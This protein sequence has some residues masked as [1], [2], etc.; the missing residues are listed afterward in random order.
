MNIYPLIWRLPVPILGHIEIT[1]YG[2]MMM[3]GFLMG[4]WLI[5]LELRR[6]GFH[7]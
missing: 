2:I 7:E 4:G 1:G 6:L 3:V 5:A